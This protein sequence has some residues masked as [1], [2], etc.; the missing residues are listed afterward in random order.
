[1]LNHGFEGGLSSDQAKQLGAG[2]CG[3]MGEA[4][5]VCEALSGAIT[6]LGLLDGLHTK[7]GLSKK[8][9]WKLSKKMRDAFHTH[10][11]STCCRVLIKPFDKDKKGRSQFCASL[12]SSI[13][14]FAAKLILE[15]NPELI[16]HAQKDYLAESDSKISGFLKKLA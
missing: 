2:F 11:S 9:F 7:N 6:G 3:G 10:F 5:C 13:A 15:F 12:T 14:A 8:K 16:K 1:M 4:G